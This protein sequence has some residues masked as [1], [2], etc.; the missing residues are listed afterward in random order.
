VSNQSKFS[1]KAQTL[2]VQGIVTGNTE[3]FGVTIG[4]AKETHEEN[5][6]PV[7]EGETNQ[8]L[9]RAHEFLAKAA[10]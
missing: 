6:A 2:E 8:S 9:R 10:S 1:A 3:W 7:S 5:S 4:P